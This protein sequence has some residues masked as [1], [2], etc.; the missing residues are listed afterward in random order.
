MIA[1]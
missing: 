1:T